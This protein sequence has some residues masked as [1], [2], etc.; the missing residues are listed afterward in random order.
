MAPDTPSAWRG[1]LLAA[2]LG[3]GVLGACEALLHLI[4]ALTPPPLVQPL[5]T[6]DGQTLKH[7]NPTYAGRF[8]A[9]RIGSWSLGWVRLTPQRFVDPPPANGLRIVL[10]G[11]STAQGYPHPR[12]L[13][14]ASY[15]NALLEAVW[16]QKSVEIIN[17]G[18]TSI[19]SFAV[20]QIVED[21]LVLQPDLVVVY[22]GHNDFYGVYGEAALRT[23]GQSPLLKRAHYALMQR[24]TTALLRYFIDR[25]RPASPASPETSVSLLEA[26]ASAGP[27][28]A[29]DPIRQ[30]A[31]EN[32]G[33]N[34]AR[35]VDLCRRRGVPVVLSTLASNETGYAPASGTPASPMKP[36]VRV[37]WTSLLD[38]AAALMADSSQ[39][40]GAAA[41]ARLE[42]AGRLYDGDAYLAYLQ[43]KALDGMGQPLEARRAFLLA[44]A[45]DPLPLRA[46]QDFNQTIRDVALRHGALLA[47]TEQAFL[48]AS[49]PAGIGWDLMV[50]HLHPSPKG[51]YLLAQAVVRALVQAPPP[52]RLEPKD[53]AR[54]PSFENLPD[55]LR[56]LPAERAGLDLAM[57]RLL[58][59]APLDQHNGDR[60]RQLLVRAREASLSPGEQRGLAKWRQIGQQAPLSL[61]VADELF[62]A[63]DFGRALSYYEAAR[64][65]SPYTPGSDLAAT[66]RWGRCL[67][68]QNE[69][70]TPEQ[71]QQ[72]ER[73]LRRARFLAHTPD[74]NPKFLAF[75]DQYG[76]R[77]LDRVEQRR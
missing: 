56:G 77:L 7:L 36:E 48:L 71:G 39:S 47:E 65:E 3:L 2:L 46:P 41:L 24:R 12:R 34:L 35:M 9:G 57:G 20:A 38:Q 25:F 10:A 4:P 73:A 18:L 42:R 11:G 53:L 26:L 62:A 51:Q 22:T 13:T 21:A 50:D 70:L 74:A 8:F 61:V 66:V 67:L 33:L 76:R 69:V 6:V 43:G 40:R 14:A 32:L 58:G 54:L 64:L 27:I 1:R 30:T 16:P 52:L 23:G 60:A 72:I 31:R 75:I 63:Q 44:R 15:L 59:E 49:P 17:V 55:I 45:R 29:Q 28:P 68:F 37:E 5:A 19:A